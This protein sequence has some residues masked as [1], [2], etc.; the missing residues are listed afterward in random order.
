MRE[1]QSELFAQNAGPLSNALRLI[2]GAGC[3]AAA[4]VSLVTLVGWLA[5]LP[6]LTNWGVDLTMKPVAALAILLITSAILPQLPLA[7]PWRIAL[8]VIAALLGAS[9]L[10]QE[11]GGLDL[12]LES[13]L[14]ST[15]AAPG[16]IPADFR[17]SPAIALA[18][19]LAGT[20]A[21]MLPIS[22]LTDAA[23][24]LAAGAG[25]IGAAALLGHLLGIDV[26]YSVH[27]SVALPTVVALIAICA[28][29]LIRGQLS[30]PVQGNFRLFISQ[31]FVPF[32][33]F[34]LFAWWSWRN[35]EA[36]ARASADRA[37]ASFSEYAQR[38][39]EIQETA[40]EA[41]LEEAKGRSAADI[42]ADRSVHEFMA[43]IDKHTHT[44]QAIILV[45]PDTG[46]LIAWSRGFP[47]PD[48]DLSQRDYFKAHRAGYQ[49]TYIGEVISAAP[50]GGLGFT[51]S[52]SDPA[53]GI[54]AGAQM[55]IDSFMQLSGTQAS[56]RDALTLARADGMA[57]VLTPPP[58]DPVGF[59]LPEDGVTL[60]LIRGELKAGTIAPSVEDHIE[61]LWQF[62]QV[63]HYPVYAIYGLDV[64]LIRAAW[65]RQIVPFGL[66]TLL[67]A[68]LTY[69]MSRRWQTAVEDRRR[70][71]NEA[72]VARVRAERAE[73]LARVEQ[74]RDDLVQ[75]IERSNDFVA[76]ADLDGRITY[77]NS[78]A[79]QMIGR[80]PERRSRDLLFSEYIAPESLH[81]FKDTF[82]PE[83]RQHGQA[84]AEMKLRNLTSGQLIDVICSTFL[85]LDR[86]GNPIQLATVTRDI[87]DRKRHEEHLN[88]LMREVNHRAKNM[89][90][91]VQAI[92][93]Q[94]AAKSP[95]DFLARFTERLQA[96]SANQDLLV[97][98]DWGGV[99][100][101]DLVRA[102]LAAFVDLI[103]SRISVH[104]PKLRFNS[105]AA[106]AVGLALH[107]LA[108]NASKYGAL[109]TETGSVEVCWRLDGNIFAMNWTERGGPPV[110][111]PTQRGFGSTVVNFMAKRSVEGEVQLD[112]APSGVIWTLT[113][114]SANALE[115]AERGELEHAPGIHDVS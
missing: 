94:T 93:H 81:Y 112:Y 88:L 67:A 29:V 22:R 107:E 69:G 78:A 14:A 57:L 12:R 61:R 108:T 46:R 95:K 25:V 54:I 85:L 59:R 32:L 58:A 102:Q 43:Q 98:N 16:S 18:V 27:P 38:V 20:A 89:L 106:Q 48:F 3:A 2:A 1:P 76:T 79:K 41:V 28:A 30:S 72:A 99:D 56:P 8:G 83:V 60:R 63:G 97:R 90:S 68:A 45:R 100:I 10:I 110:S 31:F 17:M 40:L 75:L 70:A 49:S 66:V 77:M 19:V 21:A 104:G 39:F 44:S 34:A 50:F 113:C 13:W 55:S 109:S 80:G 11:F 96:L 35:V 103:G 101:E 92:S 26:L 6:L 82:I 9:S 114:P 65:L 52:R 42:A 115:A 105:V 4:L 74:A 7:P 64:V 15:G 86:K 111:E 47:V 62:R 33:I 71:Q 24:F 23:R 53:T 36:D 51:I 5:G 37:A 73:A 91:V 84:S 87:T